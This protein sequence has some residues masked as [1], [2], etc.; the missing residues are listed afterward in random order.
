M[1]GCAAGADKEAYDSTGRDTVEFADFAA[2]CA[3]AGV[4]SW[5]NDTIVTV[6]R[7]T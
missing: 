1:T 4:S 3:G 6:E 2:T 7:K 5:H